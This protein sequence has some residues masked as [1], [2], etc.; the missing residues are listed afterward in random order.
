M[1]ADRLELIARLPPHDRIRG[2][3]S[4]DHATSADDDIIANLRALE[5]DNVTAQPAVAADS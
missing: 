3:L 4:I 1:V 2:N 5:Q